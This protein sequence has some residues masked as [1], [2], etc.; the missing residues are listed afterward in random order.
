MAITIQDQP[1]PWSPRG[2]KLMIVASSDNTGE[3]GFQY[4]VV[5]YNT[6]TDKTYTFFLSPAVDGRLYFDMQSL[7][8]LRNRELEFMHATI[9]SDTFD[10]NS[11]ALNEVSFNISEYWIVGGVLTLNEGSTEYGDPFAAVNGY[12][13]VSDGYKPDANAGGI[14]V[15]YSLSTNQSRMM[16][17]RFKD[18]HIPRKRIGGASANN[19]FIPVREA[20]Y[21]MLFIPGNDNFLA[22]NDAYKYRIILYDVDFNSN[23]GSWVNLNQVAVEGLG[24]YPANINDDDGYDIRPVDFPN[25]K[26]YRVSIKN[27]A[28]TSRTIDYVFFNMCEF[29]MCE[30]IFENIRLGWVNSRSGWD[31]FNFNKRS[32]FTN[33]IDRKVYRRTLFNSLPTIFNKF[34]RGLYQRQNLAQRVLSVTS[35]F[36]QQGEFELLRG[37]LVSNQV[38]WIHDDGTFT[39]VNIDDTSFTEKN[40]RDGKLY[41]VTLKVRMANEYWT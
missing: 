2:Q 8:Q 18:T 36:I 23:I 30:C 16:S 1:Y 21:G 5:V 15:K 35:D 11:N 20:D 31:Y 28:E 27:A 33:E 29:G 32:E 39:P 40:T 4:Q 38:H 25:W 34:D 37:L 13:Q 26:Y 17:D 12:Y 14:D 24:V 3:D 6:V 22:S 10:D 19:I 41:N 9:V 7:I